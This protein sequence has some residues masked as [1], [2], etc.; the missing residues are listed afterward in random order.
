MK[1]KLIFII[2]LIFIALEIFSVFGFK[3]LHNQELKYHI[4]IGIILILNAL[5][6]Y[7]LYWFLI[8]NTHKTEIDINY[9][10][11]LDTITDVVFII[12]TNGKILFVNSQA[13]TILGYKPKDIEGKNF[14]KF[15]PKNEIIKYLRRLK[16]V[17]LKRQIPLF[18][19]FILHADGHQIPIE[20]SAKIMEYQGKYAAIGTIR[21]ITNRK[22]AEQAL[23]ESEK[24]F[25]L[26]FENAPFGIYTATPQG[27][28]L[29]INNEALR[30]IGS[31]S[32]EASKKIN[33]LT[34]PPLIENGYAS[35]FRESIRK[36][37]KVNFER[38][39][40]SMWGKKAVISSQIIP[41]KDEFGKIVKIYTVMQDISA[42][43]L[44]E[45]RL[46]EQNEEY[47]KL[48]SEYQ[49]QNKKLIEA[50]L[51]AD[52][53]NRLKSEFLTNMSHEIR[54]PMNAIIGFSEV[55]QM[56]L[57]DEKYL[58]YVDKIMSSGNNLLGL[59]NDI[60]DLS[61]MEAKQIEIKPEKINVRKMF[62]EVALIFS[63]IS[64][65]KQIPI[66]LNINKNL[67]KYIYTDAFRLKQILMN[68]VS[69]ALKFTENGEVLIFA[70]AKHTE[71]KEIIDLIIEVSDTGIGIPEEEFQTIFQS[72]S[73]IAQEDDRLYGG[74]GLGL[75]IT[76]QLVELMK[77]SI[78]VKSKIGQGSTFTIL[79]KDIKT[80][81]D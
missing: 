42:R 18:E 43:K 58:F 57:N 33:I 13:N 45:K 15:I 29:E 38:L 11:I 68:L 26:L 32:A 8:K 27:K 34:F 75:A 14:I 81:D 10:R 40:V 31:P 65:Q 76:R 7:V 46:K 17:F 1:K 50:K 36:G 70:R 56:Q 41:L 54:T 19:N 4:A 12:S 60:L 49:N 9:K 16:E 23:I 5:I 73:R 79:F 64:K 24:N 20:I 25:R 44:A 72:F 63:G 69:N 30:I 53:S 22:K 37:K 21:D 48:V 67:K 80:S 74:T 59:I 71:N 78:S 2:I 52:E 39:Y 47:S 28:I 77:G 6:A 62:D 3:Y 66:I 35:A 55:L 61:K 51:K